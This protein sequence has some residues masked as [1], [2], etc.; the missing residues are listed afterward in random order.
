MRVIAALLLMVSVSSADVFYYYGFDPETTNKLYELRL[1]NSEGD[2]SVNKTEYVME[3]SK[4][5]F[6]A[7]FDR[8]SPARIQFSINSIESA[9]NGNKP[10]R[11][12][13]PSTG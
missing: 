12:F 13:W 10:I 5:E 3:V 6:K 2:Y 9:E 4:N 7:G 11:R 8:L 1:N